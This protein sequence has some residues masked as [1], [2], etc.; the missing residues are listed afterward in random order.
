ML[1]GCGLLVRC[2]RRARTL[3]SE[4]IMNAKTLTRPKAPNHRLIVLSGWDLAVHAAVGAGIGVLVW[5]PGKR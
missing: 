2:W 4:N 5:H 1:N 3:D